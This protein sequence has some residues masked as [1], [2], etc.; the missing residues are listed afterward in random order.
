MI[1]VFENSLTGVRIRL[2]YHESVFEIAQQGWRLLVPSYCIAYPV[3]PHDY[4]GLCRLRTNSWRASRVRQWNQSHNSD[5]RIWLPSI[6][7]ASGIR[8][9]EEHRHSLSD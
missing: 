9:H 5:N 8:Q 4:P 3:S 2:D 7:P 6:L 1:T